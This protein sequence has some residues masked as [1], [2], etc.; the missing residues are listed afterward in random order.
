MTIWIK[1]KEWDESFLHKM[2]ISQ[3]LR[4]NRENKKEERDCLAESN[5]DTCSVVLSN[6]VVKEQTFTG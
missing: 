6:R 5:T 2:K 1:K 3:Q 4:N